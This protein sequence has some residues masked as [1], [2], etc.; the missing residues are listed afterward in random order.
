[1]NIKLEKGYHKRLKQQLNFSSESF[2]EVLQLANENFFLW[3]QTTS[4][5][6]VNLISSLNK[7]NPVDLIVTNKYTNIIEEWPLTADG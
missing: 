5:E 3:K 7:G 6:I 4:D 1:M 2:D